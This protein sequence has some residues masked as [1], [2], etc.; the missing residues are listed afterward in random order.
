MDREPDLV[1]V[2]DIEIGMAGEKRLRFGGRRIAK[3]I[4][5][6]VA[7]A[8][9]MGDADQR[10]EREILLHG[11]S[12]LA[13]QVLAGDEAFFAACAPF[14]RARRVDHRLVDAL[15]GFRGDAAIAER[16]RH[17]ERVV[18][19]VGLVDDEIAPRQR[20]ERRLTGDVA[21]HRLFDIQ[22]LLRDRPQRSVA[23]EPLDQRAQAQ[24]DRH[25]A[26]WR[27]A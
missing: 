15:A 11:Q 16:P 5:I 21:R 27:R 3:A 2:A 12:R 18:G 25:I 14:G 20:A 9:G 23:I 17:R 8:L 19:I 24:Q 6:M 10:A 7:V 4:D 22:Q 1:A 26:R 13:G